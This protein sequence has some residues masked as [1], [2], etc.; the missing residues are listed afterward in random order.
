[1]WWWSPQDVDWWVTLVLILI[2]TAVIVAAAVTIPRKRRPTT[3]LAW[4]LTIFLIPY[5]GFLIFLLFGTNHL[6]S[7]RRRQQAEIDEIIRDATKS[8]DSEG[9]LPADPDWIAPLV[10][11]GRELSSIPMVPGNRITLLGSY[12]RSFTQIAREIDA[13]EE[14]VHLLYYTL[15]YDEVTRPVFDAL[16][17]AVARGVTVR[18]LY[19]HIGSIRYSGYRKMR[20]RLREIGC[21]HRPVLSIW[22]WQGGFQRIDLRNHRKMVIIDD[23]TAFMGSQ[24]L[25]DR[26]YH[27]TRSG[28]AERRWKD[29]F[30]QVDGPIAAAIDGVFMSDWF[31]ETNEQLVSPDGMRPFREPLVEPEDA[32]EKSRYLCQLIPSGPGYE[33]ENNLRIFNQLLYS[34]KERVTI[35][36]P[37]LVPDDS[38]LYAITT[39]AQR[40]VEVTL[41]V[42][43]VGD[44]FFAF[45]AQ[46]SYYESFLEAGVKIRL[47]RRP[48]ILHSKHVTVDDSVALVGSSNMDMRSFTL[49]AELMLLVCSE[50]FVERMR[51]VENGYRQRSRELTLTEWR[52]RPIAGRAFDNIAR[53]TS[54]L[55]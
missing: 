49:N 21:E 38:L 55:Q 13:A 20:R 27:Q 12:D 37:Y 25:I 2:N 41:Y 9:V 52:S 35:A 30:L 1:M 45:H 33:H 44:Q 8:I 3:A 48:Y 10:R 6:S 53:L 15:A 28:D 47:Y 26:R 19:D 23:R 4:L 22:P 7:R 31:G 43:E 40:G 14:R 46:R 36:S 51:E 24:N 16:E 5:L 29:L 34:A 54:V 11:L 50:E 32:R 18:V 42:S 17:R 39:A